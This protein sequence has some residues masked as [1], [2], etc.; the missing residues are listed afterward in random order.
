MH[1]IVVLEFVDWCFDSV[2]CPLPTDPVV[3][4]RMGRCSR[5]GGSV[6]KCWCS[7]QSSV[8]DVLYNFMECIFC[9]IEGAR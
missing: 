1:Y 5:E 9:P 4:A 7:E 2:A 6:C 3:V 8:V